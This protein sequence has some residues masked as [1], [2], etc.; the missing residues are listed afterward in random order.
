MEDPG[1]DQPASGTTVDPAFW[2]GRRVLVTGHTGFKG[3]WLTAWLR[4]MGAEVTG[5]ALAPATSP[6]LFDEA[7]LA[8]GIADL[9]GDVRD[10]GAVTAAVR[11]SGA[12]V[13]LHLAAQALVRP[14]YEAPVDTYA[15][16]VMGTVNVLEAVR[17]HPAVRAVVVVTSDKCFANREWLWP[18]REDEALGGR[19]PYSS[20]KACAELVTAA[21]RDSFLAGAGCAVATARAGNVLGGGDWAQDRLVPDIVR[22]I[23]DGRPLVLRY[24][25]AIRP[26]QHVLDPLAGYLILAQRLVGGAGAAAPD[27]A[28]AWNFAPGDEEGWPVRRIVGRLAELLDRPGDWTAQEGPLPHEAGLLRL[29]ASR[30]RA[31]LGWRPRFALDETLRLIAAW[32]AAH[33]AGT[34]AADLVDAEIGHHQ[35]MVAT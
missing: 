9:R 32:Y 2:R 5:F 21:Y 15:V 25:D 34:P 16:N 13:V 31:L 28:G 26:W 23:I 20:S 12:E 7:G 6:N 11:D 30:A 22:A 3:S 19:D 29:D 27:V 35:A 18:Y 4:R 24:P 1:T 10:L 8:E 33:A 17:A 14:S